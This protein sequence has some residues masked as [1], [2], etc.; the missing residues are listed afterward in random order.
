MSEART[1]W[2]N[3]EAWHS[4]AVNRQRVGV[5]LAA[6]LL[7]AMCTTEVVF[8]RYFAGP[9]TVNMVTAAEGMPVGTQ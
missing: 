3:L 4:R 8:L 2:H 1:I 7:I 6:G 5:L 9:G